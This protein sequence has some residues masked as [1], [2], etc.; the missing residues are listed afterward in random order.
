MQSTHVVWWS[1]LSLVIPSVAFMSPAFL[2]IISKVLVLNG[3]PYTAA[4]RTKARQRDSIFYGIIG[5]NVG[6][7]H[8]GH[9]SMLDNLPKT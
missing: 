2:H 9:L 1:D 6:V 8:V 4:A 7:V 5:D 3:I